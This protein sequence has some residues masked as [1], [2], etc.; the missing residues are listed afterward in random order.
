MPVTCKN[1]VLMRVPGVILI[2][3]RC[4]ITI[5]KERLFYYLLSQINNLIGIDPVSIGNLGI[6][7]QQLSYSHFISFGY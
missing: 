4:E 3:A 7:V 6:P 2:L 5:D 1:V